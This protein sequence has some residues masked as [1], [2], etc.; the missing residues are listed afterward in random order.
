MA[1][2]E[3]ANRSLQT[4]LGIDGTQRELG[5]QMQMVAG[6]VLELPPLGER[7]PALQ[8]RVRTGQGGRR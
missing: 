3:D 6:A 8:E 2:Y 4:S 5:R 1:A 7:I